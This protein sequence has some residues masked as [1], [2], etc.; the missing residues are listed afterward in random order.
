MNKHPVLNTQ[1]PL[2]LIHQCPAYQPTPVHDILAPDGRRLLL[3]DES[4]RFNLGAFKALGGVYAV[5]AFLLDQWQRENDN[6]LDPNCLFDDKIRSWSEQFTFVCASAGNHGIAVAKGARLFNASCRVHLAD[7]VPDSFAQRLKELNAQS[8]RSGKTYEDSM[9][10]AR[11]EC[12][13]SSGR[14]GGEFDE[15]RIILLSDSS[16]PG[17]TR[18]PTLV[19][20]GYTVLAEELRERFQ[21]CGEWPSQ[22]FLQAGVGGMAAAV[23]FHIRQHWDHQPMI[24]VVEPQAAP[25]LFESNRRGELTTVKGPLS[26]MARLDCKEPSLLAF[27]I[28][29]ECADRFEL[30]SDTEADS[31]V[32]F[33]A[34]NHIDTTPSGAAGVAAVLN[35]AKLDIPGDEKSTC[36]A[37]VTEGPV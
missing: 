34:K 35:A 10:A 17:Y 31:A 9:E 11:N 13:E 36:L 25:C 1:R 7:S 12:E 28:L 4:T 32:S 18:L 24:T 6:I 33:L 23:A 37:V 14:S 22:V 19:M 3:K 15:A 21:A 30:V 20:E 16:W 5:A 27:S 26:S 2:D 8:V 29:Q